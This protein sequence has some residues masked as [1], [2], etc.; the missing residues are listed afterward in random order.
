LKSKLLLSPQ[1]SASQ[2]S[3]IEEVILGIGESLPLDQKPEECLFYYLDGRGL[4]S[5]YEEHPKGDVY[6]IRQNTVIYITPMIR[7]Q[8]INTGDSQLRYLVM[9][10]EGGLA[11]EGDLSW[12]AITQR[13]VTV[14]KP[15][16]GSGQAT[17]RV[18]DEHSNPSKEEGLHLRI[19]DIMLRRPQK[20]SNA[21]VVTIQPGRGTRLHTHNDSEETYILLTGEGEFTW[22]EEMKPCKAGSS[23]CFPVGVKRK[24]ENKGNYPMSYI[25]F[26][27]YID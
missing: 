18:F 1:N 19:R 24:V 22:N 27:A 14:E 6:E 16:V 12:S 20:F 2:R 4:M 13:G 25:C 11:P 9:K 8:I 26:S 7:H 21:E 3:Y 10:V 15:Q 23:I 17:T 5:I